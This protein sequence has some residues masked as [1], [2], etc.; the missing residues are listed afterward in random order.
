MHSIEIPEE[1]IEMFKVMISENFSKVMTHTKSQIKKAQ[2]T[3]SRR[4]IYIYIYI[5]IYTHINTY[6]VKS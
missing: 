1:K 5:Y 6:I 4:Y 2:G 3:S